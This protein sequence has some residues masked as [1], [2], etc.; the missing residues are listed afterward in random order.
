M[1]RWSPWAI[2]DEEQVETRQRRRPN[3]AMGDEEQV[4]TR[5]RRRPNP[6][7]RLMRVGFIGA[8]RMGAP[9]VDRLVTA[10]HEVRVLGRTDDKRAA[11]AARGA[12]PVG[13]AKEAADG[14]EVMVVCVFTD[15][16]VRQIC[17]EEDLLSA[18][19]P[20]AVLVVHTTGSPNTVAELADRAPGIQVLDAPVSGGPHDIAAGR[21]TLFVGGAEDA[22]QRARSVLESYGDPV[23]H[24]GPLGS[25]QKVKLINNALFAAQIG[26]AA[27][28]AR[29]GERLGITEA[30][31]LSALPN[32]SG[33]SKA[34]GNI[35]RAGSAAAFIGAVGEFIGKD[36][37]VVRKTA[38]ELGTDLGRLDPLVDA[39][40]G[41]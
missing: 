8:G 31:L 22:V 17:L 36:V 15:E 1:P 20:G 9:M 4:E 19:A 33:A 32:G 13:D 18:L 39:G 3:P 10:G 38:T 29:L 23:L 6:A 2:R 41:K 27:E 25:G 21:V 12:T 34:M 30:A 16:Q 26:L 35:A 11:I 37:S 14:A 40:L 24:V 28:A 7:G 5:Q